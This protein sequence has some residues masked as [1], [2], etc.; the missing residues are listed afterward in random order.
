MLAGT[1]DT[2]D[3][4]SQRVA[5][6]ALGSGWLA[7]PVHCTVLDHMDKSTLKQ[8]YHLM[9]LYVYAHINS[10]LGKC[11]HNNCNKNKIESG[12]TIN[13]YFDFGPVF[14]L[15]IPWILL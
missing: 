13:F 15:F 9:M 6:Y 1:T 14:Q 12:I 5:Y 8:Q 7:H 4:S 3:A 10:K 2:E 11:S